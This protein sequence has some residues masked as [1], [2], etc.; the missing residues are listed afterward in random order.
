MIEAT[1]YMRWYQGWGT[2]IGGG[3][4]AGRVE[5]GMIKVGMVVT[6]APCSVITEVKSVPGG[7]I[8]SN[9]KS[10]SA[11]DIRRGIVCSNSKNNPDEALAFGAAVQVA[12][13]SG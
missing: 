11:K 6:F 9:A 4:P 1:A 5:T 12:I 10:V 7:N 13:L 8:G 2:E 3:L